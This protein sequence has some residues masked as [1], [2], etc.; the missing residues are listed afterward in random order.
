M[1]TTV[2]MNKLGVDTLLGS[3]ALLRMNVL[4][5]DYISSF[6]PFIA[7]I[8]TQKNYDTIDINT[9][10]MD[11]QSEYGFVIPRMPMAAILNSCAKEHIIARNDDGQY[12]VLKERAHAKSFSDEAKRKSLQYQHVVQDF[13]AYVKSKYN[14]TLSMNKGE[15]I[16]YS[17]I[18][19]NSSKTLKLHTEK[20]VKA[21]GLQKK[22]FLMIAKYIEE[23]EKN[24][25]DIFGIIQDIAT[26]HIVSSA[27]ID[28]LQEGNN[29]ILTGTY[30]SLVLYL[31]TPVVLKILGLN[32]AEMQES[33]L[34][35]LEQLKARNNKL[36]I[37]QHTFEELY[38]ILHDCERWID[39]PLYNPKYA[40]PALKTFIEKKFTQSEVG[41]FVENLENKL[42]EVGIK[43][44]KTN[45]YNSKYNYLQ[46]DD[47]IIR[48]E[49]KTFYTENI[50]GFVYERK[51]QVIERDVKSISSIFKLR[52]MKRC[53]S[54]KE[55]KYLFITTNTSLAY[56]SKTSTRIDNPSYKYHVY[57]CITDVVLGTDIWISSPV[58]KVSTFSKK[59]LLADCS[60]AM[61]PTEQLI[62]KLSQSIEKLYK[63]GKFSN[64]DYYLLKTH[65]FKENYIVNKTLNDE[66]VFS[67]RITEEI[68][69]D[70][71]AE[72]Q[73]ALKKTI[74]EQKNKIDE[75]LEHKEK[76]EQ[77]QN[78][79]RAVEQEHF[80]EAKKYAEKALEIIDKVIIAV[81]I[82]AVVFLIT[83][84]VNC[85]LHFINGTMRTVLTII[86]STATFFAALARGIV[87]RKGSN[88]R[89][90]LN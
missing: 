26:A 51:S 86:A 9:I 88:I 28:V 41:L 27:L 15:E 87:L 81:G 60:E 5:K 8:L 59:K 20:M 63:E 72:I 53:S 30:H 33:Y 3:L 4:S 25:P 6:V 67:D 68:L 1:K 61:Q 35:L 42:N 7:T 82:P 34:L 57:P 37:F 18:D 80:N 12:H 23:R 56:I 58:E 24:A 78:K 69:A 38:D 46:I 2:E 74:S 73:A 85:F 11:F 84:I 66:S 75:L 21:D 44:D 43:V 79:K 50:S 39:N 71:R 89:E 48:S 16:L 70:I 47:S 14:E 83:I 62:S 49:I 55:A 13:C 76:T 10:S 32:T 36:M 31:D 40:S 17:F 64:E 19:E 90:K 29:N 52:G 45:Y 77:E 54:Y 22:H 65:A